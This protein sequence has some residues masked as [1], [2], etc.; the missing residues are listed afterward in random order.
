VPHEKQD[1]NGVLSQDIRIFQILLDQFVSEK[2]AL[3]KRDFQEA[4]YH[5]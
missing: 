1:F 5:A 2:T 4:A 3:L